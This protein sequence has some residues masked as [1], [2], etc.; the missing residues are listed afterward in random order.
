M[1]QS[2]YEVD[3]MKDE[4]DRFFAYLKVAEKENKDDQLFKQGI[5]SLLKAPM[6]RLLRYPL[7]LERYKKEAENER[8]DSLSI[9]EIDRAICSIRNISGDANEAKKTTD[10]YTDLYNIIH[11]IEDC[12]AI[13]FN[14]RRKFIRK[15]KGIVVADN[16]LT[17]IGDKITLFIFK[18]CIEIAK[19]KKRTLAPS[20]SRVSLN[21]Q[22]LFSPPG[23]NNTAR[24]ASYLQHRELIY[25]CPG[26]DS[27]HLKY[28]E[29][30][31]DIIET[32]KHQ[33]CVAIGSRSGAPGMTIVS[34]FQIN[35]II[36]FQI[37]PEVDKTEFLNEIQNLVL[38]ERQLNNINDENLD[39]L[40]EEIEGKRLKIEDTSLVRRGLFR[41]MSRKMSFTRPGIPNFDEFE[42]QSLARFDSQASINS[43]S[44]RISVKSAF[45][46][47]PTKLF[48]KSR[49]MSFQADSRSMLNLPDIQRNMTKTF[50]KPLRKII[51]NFTKP[52]TPKEPRQS[53]STSNSM[54]KDHNST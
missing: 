18:D 54:Q 44:S 8:I 28:L 30:I 11:E 51:N 33:K 36:S 42:T 48:Q 13:L 12:P 19:R 43:V 53:N 52:N 39:S 16:N 38:A 47:S 29:S 45:T 7:L 3:R 27:K 25:F 5:D 41:T 46:K 50:T 26:R 35:N 24:G 17:K 34:P 9:D 21:H 10:G 15:V 31:F 49:G 23:N 1:K 14:A 40:I 4:N 22:A 20:S 37:E 32:E 2:K 6:Q